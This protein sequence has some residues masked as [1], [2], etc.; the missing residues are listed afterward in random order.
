MVISIPNVAHADLRLLLL[1]GRWTYQDTGLLDRTHLRFFTRESLRELLAANGLTAT[2]VERVVINP[3]TSG[4]PVAAAAHGAD[5]LAYVEADPESRTFQ[6]VVEA[7]PGAGRTDALAAPPTVERPRLEHR[8]EAEAL[9]LRTAELEHENAALHAEVEAW[10][11][12][13]D[14]AL[15]AAAAARLCPPPGADR[16]PTGR[17]VSVAMHDTPPIRLGIVRP[18][19]GSGDPLVAEIEARVLAHRARPPA[20]ARVARPAHRRRRDRALAPARSRR[21]AHGDRRPAS[22]PPPCG[23]RRCR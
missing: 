22:T 13:E 9:R 3:F 14:R 16:P 20:R 19:T 7:R 18:A 21:L 17:I 5:V 23:R 15:H 2:R 4:L 1:E 10:R 11:N 6:F 12:A 8:A